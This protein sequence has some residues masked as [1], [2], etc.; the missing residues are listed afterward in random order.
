M[1][2]IDLLK[3][4]KR[5]ELHA[6]DIPNRTEFRNTDVFFIHIYIYISKT[7]KETEKFVGPVDVCP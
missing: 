3:L 7:S 6:S 1:H 4:N 2:S 5:R